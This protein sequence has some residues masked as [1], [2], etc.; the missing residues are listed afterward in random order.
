VDSVHKL[1]YIHRDLKPDNILIDTK[2]HIKLS[3]FGLCKH[4]DIKPNIALGKPTK[5]NKEPPQLL[6]LGPKPQNTYKRNRQVDYSFEK[7][8]KNVNS[9]H[10]PLLE[11]RITSPLRYFNKMD[12]LKQWIG[13]HWG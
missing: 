2:G 8:K 11:L 6:N 4:M 7:K 1:N 5:D 12:I 13:G 9:W 3:D 10:F